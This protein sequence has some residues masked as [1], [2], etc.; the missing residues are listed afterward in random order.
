MPEDR[1]VTLSLTHAV[2][3]SYKEIPMKCNKQ[4]RDENMGKNVGSLDK[5]IRLI[6]GIGLL[7]LAFLM[8]GGF[9][10]TIGIVAAVVGVILIA[11]GLMNFCPLFKIIGISSIRSN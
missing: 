5:T 8:L 4:Q 2:V 1:L 6:A 11:T 7:V 10:T 9:G 3:V